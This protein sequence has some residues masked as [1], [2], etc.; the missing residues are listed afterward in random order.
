MYAA[1]RRYQFDPKSSE[2]IS[3][4]I[5]LCFNEMHSTEYEH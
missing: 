4:H 1:I 3:R 5:G 2:E